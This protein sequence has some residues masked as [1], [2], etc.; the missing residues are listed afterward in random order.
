MEVEIPHVPRPEVTLEW[1][2]AML[3]S[4]GYVAFHEY[5][6][7]AGNCLYD[8]LSFLTGMPAP[9]IRNMCMDVLP[10]IVGQ[11]LVDGYPAIPV[12][13][14]V[15]GVSSMVDYRR[16][17]RLSFASDGDA[18]LQGDYSCVQCNAFV[19][20][21][22]VIVWNV[23][24][25][26][27]QFGHFGSAEPLQLL[28]TGTGREGHFIPVVPK[29]LAQFFLLPL[30]IQGIPRVGWCCCIGL[31]ICCCWRGCGQ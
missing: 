15:H 7:T 20:A 1:L 29:A 30:Q 18:S 14:K 12:D 5:P 31:S 13:L 11:C 26:Q 27:V 25:W 3:D 22:D 6:F 10:T 24:G 8:S 23:G 9:Q 2:T 16:R 17:Q 19:F 4:L 28:Y 21:R